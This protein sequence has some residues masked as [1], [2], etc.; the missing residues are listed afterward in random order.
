MI[1]ILHLIQVLSL[2]TVTDKVVSNHTMYLNNSN[3]ACNGTRRYLI[4]PQRV[5]EFT[6][7]YWWGPCCSFCFLM[8]FV[9]SYYVCGGRSWIYNCLTNRLLICEIYVCLYIWMYLFLFVLF[10]KKIN[11]VSFVSF[12]SEFTK[13]QYAWLIFSI[14]N[15]NE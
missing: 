4:Y 1:Y 14:I 9:L 11:S 5:P 3:H 6:H 7:E 15:G 8:F 13:R 12:F 10:I 2:L